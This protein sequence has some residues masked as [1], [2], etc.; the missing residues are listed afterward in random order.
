MTN[1]NARQNQLGMRFSKEF[2]LLENLL[3]WP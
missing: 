2:S 3:D 1:M